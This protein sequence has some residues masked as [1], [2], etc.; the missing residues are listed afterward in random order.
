MSSLLRQLGVGLLGCVLLMPVW[1]KT[2]QTVLLVS[3]DALHPDAL[4]AAVAP[5]LESLKRPG[6]FTLQG[7]SVNPPQ[8]LIAHTAMLTGLSPEQSGKQ[9]NNWKLGQ[10]QV[11]HETLLD[12]ARQQ[13]FEPAYFYAKPKLGDLVTPGIRS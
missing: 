13:G 4:Q 1:P 7:R 10:P 8:T 5:T 12:V 9:D 11:T 2:L 6:Q 3:I